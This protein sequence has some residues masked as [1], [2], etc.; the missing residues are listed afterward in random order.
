MDQYDLV[1][2][3][4]GLV[5]GSLA[6]ALGGTGLRVCVVEAVPAASASQPSYDERVIALSWGSRRIL[7][8]IGLWQEI[9]PEA[10]PIRQVHVSDRGHF[11][12]SRLDHRDEG[13][14]ALGYVAP[15]RLLGRAIQG[16]LAGVEVLCP[17]RLLGFRLY[18]QWVDLEVALSG[19]SRLIRTR[20][21]VAADGGES[22]IRKRL[23]FAVRER[24]YGHEAV[25]TTV[26]PDHPRP[27]VAFERFT[28][29]G[30][31]AML[32]MTQGR[33]SVVWTV[34]EGESADLLRLTDEDFL[35]RL[36][37]R[38]GYRLGRLSG[39]GRRAAYPLKLLLTRKPARQRLVL[40][41]NAAHTLH[42]VAGQGFNL[43]LR[44]V[45]A[46]A[47]VLADAV[48]EGGDPGGFAPL[49]AYRRLRGRDQDSAAAATDALARLFVN[50]WLPLRVA[51]DL[52]MLGL[53]LS[54]G[55]RHLLA[56]RFM[57]LGGSQPRLAR[58]L[59]LV[60]PHR[61]PLPAGEA[62]EARRRQLLSR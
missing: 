16:G 3:G 30:P 39:L 40:I 43:G 51:R 31:L 60:S 9:A 24:S 44:D 20:L 10:A 19:E 14:E 8:G 25:I 58:G 1:I 4:G 41:G 46:L 59:P 12:F 47:E 38:F 54:P 53:D 17:A 55:L 32:P 45:A 37:S 57:G 34:R 28:D 27:G 22:G 21:L 13:V 11:G 29:T 33:Y 18:D 62:D 15:A 48:R 26:T 61:G 7:E 36:Q 52:G 35:D 6:C 56:R 23:G 50:P 42:P 2:I 49:D 5:G